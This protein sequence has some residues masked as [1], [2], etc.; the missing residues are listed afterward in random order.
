MITLSIRYQ[1]DHNKQ[2]DFEVYARSLTEPIRRCG[3]D[4]IGYF[5]PTRFAGRTNEALALINFPDLGAYERYREALGNDPEGVA[6]VAQVESTGCILCEDRGF[7]Q[8]VS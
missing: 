2:R 5:L 6:S 3:G 7:L 8:R 4:L 1:I